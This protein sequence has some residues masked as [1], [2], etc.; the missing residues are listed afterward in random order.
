MKV[1]TII[2]CLSFLTASTL[3]AGNDSTDGSW[4]IIIRG[5]YGFTIAHR[6]ALQ[7]LQEAHVKGFEITVSKPT[8][9]SKYWHADFLYPEVGFTIAAFD[10]GSGILGRGIVAYPFI[11]FPLG[12]GCW[13]VFHFRYGMGLGYIENTF[14]AVDNIKNVAVGSHF[15]GVIHLDLHYTQRL[16][17]NTSIEFGP[18]ITHYSN[19][20]VSLPNLGINLATFNLAFQHT[21]GKNQ[22]IRKP[23]KVDANKNSRIHIYAGGFPKKIYPPDGESYFA[24]TLSGLWCKPVNRKSTF[25][26]GADVFYDNSIYPRIE[27]FGEEA[28]EKINN[29]RAGVYGS[30]QLAVGQLGLIFNMGYYL[31]NAWDNDGNFYHRIGLRYYFE[32]IFLC[33]N[34]KSH[35][36]RADFFEFGAGIRLFTNKSK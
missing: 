2:F 31:Y 36:A 14:D 17:K 12:K 10:L 26:L 18:A 25:G 9:G 33:V 28:P 8:A 4:N 23:E 24:I 19:G 11:D 27:A 20:S 5:D 30:Y 35:Y 32:K 1:F 34:L 6:P 13:N 15:N 29:F 16:A 22:A 7:P 21:F 3:T